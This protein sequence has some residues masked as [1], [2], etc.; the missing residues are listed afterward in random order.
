MEIQ[1]IRN[2]SQES[3]MLIRKQAIACIVEKKMSWKEV[4]EIFSIGSIN[5]N[6]DPDRVFFEPI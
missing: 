6:P 4:M 1:N 3:K 5:S 2:L